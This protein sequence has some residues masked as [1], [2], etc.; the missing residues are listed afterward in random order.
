MIQFISEY[1]NNKS[2]TDLIS[3]KNKEQ[4]C[5]NISLIKNTIEK[6]TSEIKYDYPF[7]MTR[8]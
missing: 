6:N 8:P 3:I 4:I 5:K 1:L 2:G 7:A